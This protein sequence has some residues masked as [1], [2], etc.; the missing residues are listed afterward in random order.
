ML[1]FKEDQRRRLRLQVGLFRLHDQ[2]R[3]VRLVTAG[4]ALGNEAGHVLS[5]SA[6]Y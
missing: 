2:E 1:G 6:M 5:G 4:E 3:D